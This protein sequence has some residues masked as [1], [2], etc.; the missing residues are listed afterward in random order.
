MLEMR[1]L[2]TLAFICCALSAIIGL[3]PTTARAAPALRLPWPAGH[4]HRIGPGHSYDCG[5]HKGSNLYAIDF[6]FGVDGSP[7]S[8]TATAGTVTIAAQGYN[9]G[10]GNY[11][12]VDHGG[13]YVSRY[14]HLQDTFAPGIGVGALVSQGQAIGNADNSGFSTG[15]H[16]H[17]DVRLNG[18]AYT[19]EPMSSVT[20]FGSY[21]GCG[22]TSPYWTSMP[23]D[24]IIAVD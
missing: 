21:G 9:D 20:G 13:G 11:V 17:F 22:V 4:L 2:P 19:P 10:A 8:V 18:S 1:R 12:A 3:Q 24:S 14:L 6:Q 15:T 16:L 7:L 23:P 5:D